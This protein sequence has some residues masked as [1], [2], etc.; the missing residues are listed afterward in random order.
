MF[1]LNQSGAKWTTKRKARKFGQKRHL[2]VGDEKGRDSWN[3]QL[4]RHIPETQVSKEEG[5]K[6]KQQKRWLFIIIGIPSIIICFLVLIQLYNSFSDEA[7]R[8]EKIFESIHEDI[9][10][11][12][13]N[14]FGYRYKEGKKALANGNYDA[15]IIQFEKSI[16][17]DIPTKWLFD[18]LIFACKQSCKLSNKNC[19]KIEKYQLLKQELE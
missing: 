19:D 9:K 5:L 3:F 17:Q 10:E 1:M 2:S 8:Q 7:I 15:A 14:V 18:D 6:Q 16:K 12:D 11:E 4:N 13:V